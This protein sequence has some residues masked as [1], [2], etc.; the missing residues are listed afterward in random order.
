MIPTPPRPR[1]PPWGR[2]TI[3]VGLALLLVGPL[4]FQP[5][6]DND[7]GWHLALGRRIL[8]AGLPHANALTWT[9]R[10]AP[11]YDTSWL[12]DVA[13]AALVGRLGLAGLQLATFAALS[14]TLWALGWAC[15]Q[16]DAARG[17]W[18]VPA[19]ALL[20]V[21]RLLARPHVA[22][23]AALAAVLALCLAGEG[24]SARFR[25]ACVPLI[26]LAG[27]LHS[28]AIFAAGVLGLF[29]LEELILRKKPVELAIAAAGVAALCANPG[30]VFDLRSMLYH[31]L[32]VQS[33]VVIGEYLPP[34]PRAEPIFFALVPVALVLGWRRRREEFAL[35]AT[36]FVFAAL[37]LKAGRMVYEFEIVAAPLLADGLA[38]LGARAGARGQ[39]AAA[40]AL[41]LAC[42]ASHGWPRRL[43][44]HPPAA[45]WDPAALPVRAA[46]FASAHRLSGPFFHSYDD[47]GYLEWA[48]PEVPAFVDGRVQ[49]FPEAFF[50][51]FY[52][53]GHGPAPFDRFLR[54]EGAEWAMP[55]RTSPWLSGRGL[56]DGNPGWA[57]VYWDDRNEI[58][59]RRDVAR[60]ATLIGSFEYLRF[61]PWGAIVGAVAQ[62]PRAE[63][64]RTLAEVARFEETTPG[65]PF[66]A[67]VRCAVRARQRSPSAE[68]DCARARALARD[69]RQRA[70]A[71]AAAR[72][73]PADR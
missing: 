33:V 15:A 5:I 24:G 3:F 53:A 61:R 41:A 46:A 8:A 27:N 19:V 21:P 51:R 44:A 54:E 10:D 40:A 18:V 29:C 38:R 60:F 25:A 9:A 35:L 16:R 57:L 22:A 11:W 14:A 17:A 23:W 20:L 43:F 69:P 49:A 73:G 70:L 62:T 31:L 48:L 47:G 13:T 68:A 50:R 71:E 37:A 39:A 58:F 64:E 42:G 66:A 72:V 56:L 45:A 6:G 65:D 32:H 55:L 34:S 7:A 67:I 26:A 52:A 12:W 28:G 36:V 2:W 1:T 4:C 63:L 59:L 30:G